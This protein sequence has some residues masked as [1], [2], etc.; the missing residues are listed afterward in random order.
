MRTG[1]MREVVGRIRSEPLLLP[2]ETGRLELPGESTAKLIEFHLARRCFAMSGNLK[3]IRMQHST[4]STRNRHTGNTV[5][6]NC[7]QPG[8]RM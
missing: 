8:S 6:R 7:S 3:R 4:E 1:L 5:A 2:W